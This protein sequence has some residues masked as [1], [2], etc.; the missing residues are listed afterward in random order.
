MVRLSSLKLLSLKRWGWVVL[1]FLGSSLYAGD[2]GNAM[3]AVLRNEPKATAGTSQT[4]QLVDRVA[5]A[6]LQAMQAQDNFKALHAQIHAVV[7][8]RNFIR[9]HF[10]NGQDLYTELAKSR[11]RISTLLAQWIEA[12]EQMQVQR[13]LLSSLTSGAVSEVRG[14]TFTYIPS[15]LEAT[16]PESQLTRKGLHSNSESGS[17]SSINLEVLRLYQ[18]VQIGDSQLAAFKSALEWNLEALES[19]AKTQ[20]TTDQPHTDMIDTMERVLQSQNDISKARYDNLYQRIRLCAQGGMEPNAIAAH[21]DALL[22]G[23]DSAP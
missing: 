23:E 18:A 22:R 8:Q 9:R 20:D 1:A 6:Y 4:L 12:R 17:E 3:H 5:V 14:S 7:M 19:T 10:L 21:I 16:S 15:P 11:G 2:F 13:K